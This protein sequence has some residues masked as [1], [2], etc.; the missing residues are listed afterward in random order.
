MGSK[1]NKCG[2]IRLY[3]ALVFAAARALWLTTGGAVCSREVIP[4][5][6]VR[7]LWSWDYSGRQWVLDFVNNA[8][9]PLV[10]GPFTTKIGKLGQSIPDLAGS[11]HPIH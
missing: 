8:I 2:L 10:R 5:M 3:P 11:E 9:G 4:G 7:E 6:C 1:D